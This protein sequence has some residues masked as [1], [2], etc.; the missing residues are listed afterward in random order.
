MKQEKEIILLAKLYKSPAC[1]DTVNFKIK[2]KALS[3][4]GFEVYLGMPENSKE[5]RE[6][7]FKMINLKIIYYFEDISS[8]LNNKKHKS[9][10]GYKVDLSK[11]MKYVK[12]KES[13]LELKALFDRDRII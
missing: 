1:K 4:K 12:T 7:F 11:L 3:I 10:K 2:S 9:V 6:W 13:Y 5:F 8:S